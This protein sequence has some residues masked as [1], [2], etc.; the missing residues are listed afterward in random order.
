MAGVPVKFRCYRCNTLL[1]VS[2]SKIG[3]VIACVKCGTELVVPDPDETPTPGDSAS[4]SASSA[5]N[6][7]EP[8]PAF[9]SALE[10]GVP[11]ALQDIHPE[12]IRIE[13]GV[14]WPPVVT[15]PAPPETKPE[16][17]P[18][19]EPEPKPENESKPEPAPARPERILAPRFS[20]P[21]EPPRPAAAPDPV[22]PTIEIEPVKIARERTPGR[23]RDLTIPRTVVVFWSFFVLIAQALGFV[24][25]LLA[26]HYLWRVH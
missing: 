10:A 11:L 19:P 24:A 14:A 5:S 12:D 1:G 21:P 17:E 26:G 7:A 3:S 9:L 2:R 8:T 23:A 6:L 4:A 20:P 13:P 18:A 25:G 16:P 22:V 15:S